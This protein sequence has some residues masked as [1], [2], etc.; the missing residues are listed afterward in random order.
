MLNVL[1]N[2]SMKWYYGNPIMDKVNYQ[3]LFCCKIREERWRKSKEEYLRKSFERYFE[4]GI[5]TY[6]RYQSMFRVIA[7]HCDG[8]SIGDPSERHHDCII[9]NGS[10][11]EWFEYKFEKMLHKVDF[12]LVYELLK[13][14]LM[15]CFSIEEIDKSLPFFFQESYLSDVPY[16]KRIKLKLISS[17]IS[18]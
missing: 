17:Y 2:T 5:L 6:L 16:C 12:Y 15:D 18:E 7:K 10:Y 9:R 14:F 13:Y 1:A 8:C 4:R 3:C 11:S